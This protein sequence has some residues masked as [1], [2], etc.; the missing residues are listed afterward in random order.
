MPGTPRSGAG[1]WRRSGSCTSAA[2]EAF[3]ASRWR[4]RSRSSGRCREAPLTGEATSVLAFQLVWSGE[5]ERARPTPR[6]A[7]RS[8]ERPGRPRGD[9]SA[10]D[11]EPP[12]VAGRQLGAGRPPRGRLA[13]APGAVRP[14]GGAADV[15]AAGRADRGAP[16]SNRGRSRSVGARARARRGRRHS[17]RRSRAIAGCSASSSSRSAIRRQR[18]SYLERAWEIRDSVRVLEPG[19]RLELADTLE[20]LIAVGELE[21]AEQ[22]LAAVGGARPDA[23][24]LVGA[25]DHGP[26]PRAPPR[27]AGRSRGR[28]RRASSARW[29]STRGRRIR[30][31]TRARCSRKAITQRRAKQRGAARA[32]ARAGARHLRAARRAALGRAGARRAGA[33]RRPRTLARRADRG[34]APD[35][36]ARR[37][38]PHQPRGRRGPLRHRAHR[39][40]R[41]DARL[42]EARRPLPHRARAPARARS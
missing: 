21:E 9:G 35:R 16:G 23:R 27:R 38:G 17:H 42:P 33:D 31:S 4:R 39:R 7:A 40:G 3:R 11:A 25:G 36:G 15:G 24:P 41:A 19:H 5:L 18:S 29:P 32:D 28:R 12:R 13:R 1:R 34:R 30:S 14:R 2:G 6:R 8:P 20:A 10:L 22:K 37:R 26:L